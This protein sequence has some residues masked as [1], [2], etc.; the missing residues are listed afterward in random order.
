MDRIGLRHCLILWIIGGN[1]EGPDR[2]IIIQPLLIDVQNWLQRVRGINSWEAVG[3][4][5]MDFKG[6]N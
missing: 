4:G 1:H 2:G 3:R 5:T 6:L